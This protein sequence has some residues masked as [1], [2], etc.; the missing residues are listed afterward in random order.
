M[1]IANIK[2]TINTKEEI[3]SKVKLNIKKVEEIDE[4][5]SFIKGEK[6]VK[7]SRC[8]SN[9]G[10]NSF[11]E[12]EVNNIVNVLGNILKDREEELEKTVGEL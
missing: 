12:N 1:D 10:I 6:G 7:I 8:Y 11:T 9:Y 4:L 3:I 2:N 5:I